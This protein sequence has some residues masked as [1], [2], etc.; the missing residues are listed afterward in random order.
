MMTE[1]RVR[2]IVDEDQE[3]RVVAVWELDKAET[4]AKGEDKIT[5]AFYAFLLCS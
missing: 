2:T 1:E 5:E 4:S 3:R